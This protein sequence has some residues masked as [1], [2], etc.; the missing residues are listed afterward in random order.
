MILVAFVC[1]FLLLV[2]WLMAPSKAPVTTAEPQP[3]AM[4]PGTVTA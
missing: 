3:P 4:V 1:F 2:A